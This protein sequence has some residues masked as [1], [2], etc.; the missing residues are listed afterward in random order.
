MVSTYVTYQRIAANLDQSLTLTASKKSVQL[1]SDYY[2][3]KIGDVKSVEEFLGDTRLFK[4]AMTAFGLEDMAYAKGMIRK[5]LEEGVS[6][7]TSFAN[8]LNDDRFL[9]LAT[10]FDFTTNGENT[11]A[12]T[13]ARQGVVDKYVRQTME[14]NAGEENDGVR[15]ALYFQRAA[16]KVESA[17]GLLADDALW[18]VVKTVYG[19]PDEMANADIDKQAAAVEKRLD[20]E[21]LKDPEKL[22]QLLVRFTNMW[23]VTQNVE[24]SPILNLFTN[25]STPSIG[26]DLVMTLHNLKHGGG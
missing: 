2:L 17:Y 16:P 5:V 25:S 12:T 21:D 1:E 11:T 22:A 18:E 24:P 15:L 13:A 3:S 14:V 8:R 19:F 9:D 20:I 26:L 6:D 7:P 23:D 4:F 10:V